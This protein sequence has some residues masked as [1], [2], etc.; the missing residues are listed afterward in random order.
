MVVIVV[1]SPLE[2]AVW[3]ALSRGVTRIWR[4]RGGVSSMMAA[5]L[6]ELVDLLVSQ[7][8]RNHHNRDAASRNTFSSQIGNNR[9]GAI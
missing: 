5:R 3:Q 6:D 1:L 9:P 8:T 4:C 7:V 2:I